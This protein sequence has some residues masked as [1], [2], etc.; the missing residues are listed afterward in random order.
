MS[1]LFD[2]IY[3]GNFD[4]DYIKKILDNGAHPD[5]GHGGYN[6]SPLTMLLH[7]KGS[8]YS[9]ANQEN[10]TKFIEIVKLMLK[11]GANPVKC[12]P[13]AD[14]TPRDWDCPLYWSVYYSLNEII[15]CMVNDYNA[16]VNHSPDIIFRM[17]INLNYDMLKLFA[18]KGANLNIKEQSKISLLQLLNI[19]FPENQSYM[20]SDYQNSTIKKI[21]NLLNIGIAKVIENE[22]IENE[23]ERLERERLE[24]ERLERERLER[25]RLERERLERERLER[26][27]LERER[28]E[29][30][31][32]ERERLERE[33]LEKERL[34]REQ[35]EKERLER[36]QLEKE[37]LERE[38]LERERLERERL[39]RER[40]ERE[41]HE[42]ERLDRERLERERLERERLERERLEREHQEKDETQSNCSDYTDCSNSESEDDMMGLELAAHHL[43]QAFLMIADLETLKMYDLND[44]NNKKIEKLVLN[45]QASFNIVKKN[46]PKLM[47]ENVLLLLTPEYKDFLKD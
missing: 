30:E 33:R 5:A 18:R 23:R 21:T 44:T 42:R 2:Y 34:E 13:N 16:N 19:N 17:I 41:R 46:M 10:K 7:F 45:I 31:R 11:K 24:R 12:S 40:L 15:E 47:I 4:L 20:R 35:L 26:E 37:R 22:K 39:E 32:L 43:E 14:G 29:R 6:S 27:R 8:E 25:E 3:N 28:L 9:V 38:R 36:E 1:A